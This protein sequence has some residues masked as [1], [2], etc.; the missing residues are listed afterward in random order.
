MAEGSLQTGTLVGFAGG[1]IMY[2]AQQIL[3][4]IQN[5]TVWLNFMIQCVKNNTI[6]YN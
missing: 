2:L 3:R 6:N 5:N 1:T 4:S